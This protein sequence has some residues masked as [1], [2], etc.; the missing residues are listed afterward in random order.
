MVNRVLI[1][2]KVVQILYSYY[3]KKSNDLAAAEKELIFSLN[4]SYELYHLLLLLLIALTREEQLRID[5]AKNKKYFSG[6]TKDRERDDTGEKANF[7]CI[8]HAVLHKPGTEC[9]KLT[10]LLIRA[11]RN[12]LSSIILF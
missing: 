1:R 10:S 8:E 4:K 2:I 3:L 11:P 12:L 5:T 9:R 7:L 6:M